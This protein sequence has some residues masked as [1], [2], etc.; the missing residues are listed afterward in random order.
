MSISTN[1]KSLR[2]NEETCRAGLK[3]T[4]EEDEQLM[5]DAIEGIALNDVA[6]KHHRTVGSIKVRVMSNGLKMMTDRN[7]TLEEVSNM[8]HISEEELGQYKHRLDEKHAKKDTTQKVNTL[9]KK[10]GPEKNFTQDIISILSEIR[11][12]L[13]VISEKSTL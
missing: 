2:E 1:C 10:K 12:Y 11:D 5:K 7:L 13:K 3:W 9:F 8:I 6:L 4:A